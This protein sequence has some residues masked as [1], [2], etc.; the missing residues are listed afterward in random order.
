[1]NKEIIK[2]LLAAAEERPPERVT[3]RDLQIPLDSAK[4]V[5]LLGIRRSG[6]T[7]ILYETMHRLADR[8]VD[9]RCLIHLNFE[10]DRLA[11]TRADELDLILKAHAELHPDLAGRRRYLFLDE[12]QNAPG[13]EKYVRRILD[14]ENVRIFITG[15]SSSLLQRNIASAMRGR[16]ISFEVFPLSF[17]EFLR[18]R[19][20]EWKRYSSASEARV[21]AALEEYLQTGGFPEVVL[22]D[23]AL[24]L[25][26]LKEYMDLIIY[27]D[28]LERY[29]L[30]NPHLARLMLRQ[31]LSHPASFLTVHKLHNDLRSQG[32]RVSKNTLYEY[33]DHM[34][35]SYIIFTAPKHSRSVRKQAVN[36]RK[37]FTIDAALSRVFVTDPM[38]DRGHKL[39]NAVYL[40]FRRREEEIFYDANGA[41]VDLVIGLLRPSSII[42][43]S[44]SLNDPATLK[45]EI[46]SLQW[47]KKTHP[48]ARPLLVAHE[49]PARLRVA[50]IQIE[51]AWKFLL[52]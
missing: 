35:E 15:S 18:F 3:P 27:K 28:L 20:I 42:N 29:S 49:F 37:V 46:A 23:A 22:A 43:V 32:I 5:V 47:A 16:S 38:Q 31:F 14:T 52:R 41:E 11:P 34:V 1:M 33:M 2:H 48:T 8:G 25:K 13:W 45:H 51:P 50:N 30:D 9:R 6:K 4:P 10:D 24:R 7:Y 12:V 44:Y 40:H 26:I 21:V 19:K 17:S 36:P 39:E